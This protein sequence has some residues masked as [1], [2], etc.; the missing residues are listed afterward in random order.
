VWVKVLDEK[1]VLSSRLRNASPRGGHMLKSVRGCAMQ[2][3]AAF[4]PTRIN[5]L[6]NNSRARLKQEPS[7]GIQVVADCG[8]DG[9]GR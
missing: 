2:T 9:T 5:T 6:A 8:R 1:P 3:L 7:N 4:I